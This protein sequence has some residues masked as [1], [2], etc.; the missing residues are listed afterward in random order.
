AAT[1]PTTR[2]EIPERHQDTVDQR[3]FTDPMMKKTAP[4][5]I[6]EIVN[7]LLRPSRNGISGIR[8]QSAKALKVVVAAIQGERGSKGRPYSSVNIVRTQRSGSAV[9]NQTTRSRSGPAKP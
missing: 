5:R 8:P 9:I 4:V 6:T 2:V 7:A 3:L 1:P